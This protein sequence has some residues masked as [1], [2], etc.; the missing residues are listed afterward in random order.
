MGTVAWKYD[1]AVWKPT[2]SAS[3]ARP[4]LSLMMAG[5]AVSEFSES[6]YPSELTLVALEAG[7]S[8]T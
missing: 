8:L 5:I 4:S 2:W 6:G 7:S 3:E 1:E